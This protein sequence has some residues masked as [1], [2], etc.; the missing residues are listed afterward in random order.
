MFGSQQTTYQS[1]L[2][3]DPPGLHKPRL[4]WR[5]DFNDAEIGV[6]LRH[7]WQRIKSS[8]I[9]LKV[10]C[11]ASCARNSNTTGADCKVAN[12]KASREYG[13]M[14][15]IQSAHSRGQR[16]RRTRQRGC[17]HRHQ[18]VWTFRCWWS[19]HRGW[20]CGSL[21]CLRITTTRMS[22]GCDTWPKQRLSVCSAVSF[23]RVLTGAV[24]NR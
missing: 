22:D 21:R 7:G 11:R 24:L 9:T 15:T 17:G 18:Q 3:G 14:K 13:G 1:W 23:A 12:G 16:I 19:L 6:W 8:W 2:F 5:L 4:W 10:Q 20:S